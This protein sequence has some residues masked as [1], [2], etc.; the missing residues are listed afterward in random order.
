MNR[1]VSEVFLPKDI[2]ILNIKGISEEKIEIQYT[3]LLE[4][5]P[6]ISLDRPAIIDD[7]IVKP[8]REL[9]EKYIDVYNEYCKSGADIQKFVPASGAASRMFKRLFEVLTK[10]SDDEVTS[11]AIDNK[12]EYK[13]IRQFLNEIKSFAFYDDLKRVVAQKDLD[14][15]SMIND[16]YYIGILSYLITDLGLN[17]GKLPK[18]LLKFHRYIDECRTPASEH[19]VEAAKYAMQKSAVCKIHF[20]VSPE[21]FDLFNDHIDSIKSDYEKR[22]NVVYDISFSKQK[23]STD[24]I[25]VD[26]D[27]KP[28][29]DKDGKLF[30]RPGGHGA[31]IENLND[32]DADLVFVK[33]IDNVAPDRLKPEVINNKKVLAGL[34]VDIQNNIKHFMNVIDSGELSKKFTKEIIYFI[35]HNLN[36]KVDKDVKDL[37]SDKKIKYFR[38]ILNRP[39]RVCGMVKNEGEPGGGPFWVKNS[40]GN[41]SLQIVE[42]SQIDMNNEDQ[43]EIL[44]R[45]THFNP[46]DL[47]CGLKDYKGNKFNL[48]KYID[49]NTGFIA[50]K[51]VNGKEIKALELPGLWNGAMANWIT[52]F[53]EVPVSTFSPVKVVNDLLREEHK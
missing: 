50:D 33:N 25:S 8:C 26:V 37:D 5:F 12:D 10:L 28:F 22:F 40:K 48:I 34:L 35:E 13:D 38:R 47:V 3:H 31:L 27:N 1:S 4:G 52:I 49:H 46:V 45:S 23:P 20:T 11:D 18:G 2:E 6:F 41:L 16:K 36:I 53:A 43:K 24:T 7:G 44:N 15:E 32:L 39:I 14:L 51:S 9:S 30:F 21:H 17:Y 42:S 19:L 29:R